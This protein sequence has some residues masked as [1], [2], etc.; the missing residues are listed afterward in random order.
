MVLLRP[1]PGSALTRYLLYWLNSPALAA[2]VWGFRDGTVAERLNLPTIR[3]L[4]IAVPPLGEQ[5]AIARILGSLD[6]KIALNR[7]MNRTLEQLAAAIF[8]SWFVDFDPVAAR[9]A[10][11]QPFG[12]DAETAALFP[13]AFAE[14]E[15]GA[16]PVGWRMGMIGDLFEVNP[17]RTLPQGEIAPYLDMA[18][19]PTTGHSPHTW[20][21]RAAGSG[22]R[23]ING[24]TLLARITPCLENGKTAFVD[25]LEPN[26]IGWGS[27]EYIVLRPKPPLPP[28][29]A[30]CLARTEALRDFAVQT[31]SGSSGRQRVATDAFVRYSFPQPTSDVADAFCRLVMPF[32]DQVR[33]NVRQ[34]AMLAAIRDALLPKLMSGEIRVG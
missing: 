32:F 29:F 6:D 23:F 31:M 26:Q 14:S 2:Y 28:I 10:G 30:Y 8:K 27:T 20:T 12:M 13:A 22:M 33:A 17:K 34:S 5:R 15:A 4:P 3:G 24:D 11:Q 19:M 1:V 7:R 16:V 21:L 18:N 9:A 25:F